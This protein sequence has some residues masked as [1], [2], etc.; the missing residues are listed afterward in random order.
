M[1]KVEA[2]LVSKEKKSTRIEIEEGMFREDY[3]LEGDAYSRSGIERQ[4]TV[5]SLEG[6][7][8]V[9]NEV[10]DGLCFER[11]METI[12]ISGLPLHKTE[13]GT[14][15]SIGGAVFEV[16]KDRKKCYP[17]CSIVKSGRVCSLKTDVRFLKVIKSGIVRKGDTVEIIK[18]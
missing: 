4:V 12:R 13:T 6:R 10:L 3:G 8:A 15:F 11:F 7:N 18:E 14:Q 16:V 5:L 2:I 1:G 17:E 9:Q